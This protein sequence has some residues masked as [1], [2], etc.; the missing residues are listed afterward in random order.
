MPPSRTP[1]LAEAAPPARPAWAAQLLQGVRYL[2][3]LKISGIT[4]FTWLFFVAYF[5]LLRNPVRPVF[6]MP[7]TPLD[8]AIGHQAWAFAAYVSLWLYVGIAPGVLPRFRDLLLYGAWAAALCCT[9]LL[10]FYLAPTAVPPVPVPADV[11]QHPGFALLQGVDAAGNACPSLHVATALF[12]ALW[13]T[14]LLRRVGAPIVLQAI[15]WLWL[16][17]IVYSTLAI[18][19][20]V[21]LDALAGAVLGGAFAWASQRWWPPMARFTGGGR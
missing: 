20:H 7:L 10:I 5:Y 8:H 2:F 13:I 12:S 18:K 4:A 14:R 6:V 1:P 15:N 16:A 9:G 17:L 19:Q 11:A 21:V 3:W